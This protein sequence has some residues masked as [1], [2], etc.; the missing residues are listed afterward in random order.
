[1]TTQITVTLIERYQALAAAQTETQ[2]IEDRLA[3]AV[4]THGGD[5]PA[6]S[7]PRS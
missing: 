7:P 3:R 5:G 6:S 4:L 1:M 2:R